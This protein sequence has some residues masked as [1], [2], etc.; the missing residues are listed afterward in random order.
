MTYDDTN[1]FAKMIRGQIP[2]DAVYEN[3]FVLAFR[4]IEPKAKVHILVVPKNAY[5]SIDDFGDRATPQEAHAFLQAISHIARAQ[6]LE[7]MGYRIIMNHKTYAGQ[8]VF[9][10]HAHILGGEPLGPMISLG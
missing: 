6:D 10:F 3:E 7:E 8:Q 2:C 4:D 5:V 1:I 9:H